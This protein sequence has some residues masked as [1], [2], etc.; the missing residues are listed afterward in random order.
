MPSDPAME[1]LDAQLESLLRIAGIDGNESP[2]ESAPTEDTPVEPVVEAAMTVDTPAVM[3]EPIAD[4]AVAAEP[5]VSDTASAGAEEPNDTASLQAVGVTPASSSTPPPPHRPRLNLQVPSSVEDLDAQL[6]DLTESLLAK[7]AETQAEAAAQRA[8]A[9]AAAEAAATAAEAEASR[10]R[11]LQP[12][13]NTGAEATPANAADTATHGT[14][15]STGVPSRSH[16][17]GRAGAGS[18]SHGGGQMPHHAPGAGH[19]GV[20]VGAGSESGHGHAGEHGS[21]AVK[22]AGAEKLREKLSSAPPK[23]KAAIQTAAEFGEKATPIGVKA[24]AVMNKPLEGKSATVRDS[25]G[26]VALWTM[27]NAVCVWG[28]VVFFQKPPEL[29]VPHDAPQITSDESGSGHGEGKDAAKTEGHAGGSEGKSHEGAGDGHEEKPAA[30]H[31]APA[32]KSNDHG[33]H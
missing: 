14:S 17:S 10:T 7:A 8:A 11:G 20:G 6:A 28:F 31:D 12:I 33:G 32:S 9:A 30:K 1:S 24:L 19:A 18:G 29:A 5:V 26:W 2:A 27:F 13:D 25:L 3:T 23:V 16:D 15:E 21:A 4:V 22:P